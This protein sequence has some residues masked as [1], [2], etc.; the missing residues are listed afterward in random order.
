[1]TVRPSGMAMFSFPHQSPRRNWPEFAG[2]R[3]IF[4]FPPFVPGKKMGIML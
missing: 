4:P 2:A 3:T 1:M